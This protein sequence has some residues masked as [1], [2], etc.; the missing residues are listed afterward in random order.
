MDKIRVA[1]TGAA[2]QIGSV[3]MRRMVEFPNIHPVAICRNPISA[4]MIK[5]S[6]PRCNIKIG[7]ITEVES[8]VKILE[9]ADIIIHCALATISGNPKKSRRLNNEM[10]D[11]FCRLAKVK[12]I[13][14]L[15]SISVYGAYID[16]SKSRFENPRSD[17]DYGRSKLKTEEYAKSRFK[18]RRLDYYILRLG[19]VY[20]T[21]MDR[22]RQMI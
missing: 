17:S 16:Q 15:S 22:S 10:I 9:N 18:S 19:H 4:G 6:A 11:N 1:V 7:S 12:L 13:I 5:Y 8:A 21:K 20:G 14:H 3:L 2:G